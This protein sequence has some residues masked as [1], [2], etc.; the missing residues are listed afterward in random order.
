MIDAVQNGLTA[1]WTTRCSTRWGDG[2]LLIDPLMGA[3]RVEKRNVLAHDVSQ[4]R[5]IDD[6][7]LVQAF[8]PHGSNPPFHAGVGVRGMMRDGDHVDACRPE[9]C[10]ESV[11]ELLVVVAD[12]KVDDW[13]ALGEIPHHLARLLRDSGVV[14]MGGTARKMHSSAADLD[15]NEDIQGT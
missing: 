4:M 6:Q 9:H 5:L 8:F 2:N 13:F 14:G 1:H 15:K 7:H 12:Q 3:R 10:F 11:A